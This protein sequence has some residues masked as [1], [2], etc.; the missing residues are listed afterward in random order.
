MF[1]AIIVNVHHILNVLLISIWK[2]I[3]ENIYI[4]NIKPKSFTEGIAKGRMSAKHENIQFPLYS[5]KNKP[6]SHISTWKYRMIL[7][8][9]EI[10]ILTHVSFYNPI[11]KRMFPLKH[12]LFVV[13][14]YSFTFIN[15][16]PNIFGLMSF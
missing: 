6:K 12:I 8:K 14:I 13:N 10:W 15:S 4:C 5:Q 16:D 7:E 1:L 9:E 11:I 2:H 3:E